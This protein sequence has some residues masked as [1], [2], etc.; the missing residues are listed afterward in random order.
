YDSEFPLFA[1][2]LRDIDLLLVPS[3]TEALAG[4]SR[5]RIGAM[6][7]ALEQQ[8]VSVMSSL[9]GKADWNEA[10]EINTG[11]GGIFCPPDRGFPMTGVMAEGI[12][13]QPGWTVAE[14]DLATIA[15]VRA[16][17]VVLN[18]LHWDEQVGRDGIPDTQSMR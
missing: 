3:C 11:R 17:G 2:A 9:I 10:V 14:V 16:D 8:C 5:V 15:D 12:M 7:R 1:R 6:A 13:D 18:R 4:Y